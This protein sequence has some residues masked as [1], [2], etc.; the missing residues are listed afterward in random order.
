MANVVFALDAS[1]APVAHAAGG[2]AFVQALG[3]DE[4]PFNSSATSISWAFPTTA[5]V[6]AGDRVIV[7]VTWQGVAPATGTIVC[8]DGVGNTYTVDALRNGGSYPMSAICSAN[9]ATALPLG[10]AINVTVPAAYYATASAAEFSGIVGTGAWDRG[11]SQFGDTTTASTPGIISSGPTSI[12]TQ[13]DELVLG[14]FA[15]FQAS[16]TYSL[17]TNGTTNSCAL[18]GTPTSDITAAPDRTVST[19]IVLLTTYCVVSATGA[20]APRISIPGAVQHAMGFPPGPDTYR[21]FYSAS[22]AT[23][24][25]ATPAVTTSTALTALPS[26]GS[27]TFGQNVQFTAT[28]SPGPPAGDVT[29]MDGSV[30][31]GSAVPLSAG[32]ATLSTATLTVGSHPITAVYGGNATNAA[33][34]SSLLTQTVAMTPQTITFGGLVDKLPT[35]V[36]FALTASASSGLTVVF[37]STTSAVCSVSGAT[38]HLV[39]A[40]T[41]SIQASQPGTANYGSAPPVTQSFAVKAL[42]TI[43]FGSLPEA[44]YGA[45]PSPLTAT[46]SS[47]LAVSFVSTTPPVCTTSGT[48]GATLTILGAGL[49]SIDATQIGSDA[50]R[51]AAPVEQHFT[52]D[53]AASSTTLVISPS[54]SQAGD[55]V[56][57]QASVVPAVTGTA[58]PGGSLSFLD[59]GSLLATVNLD[60]SGLATLSTGG[61]G[62]GTHTFVAQYAGSV[63]FTGSLGMATLTVSARPSSGGGSSH[64]NPSPAAPQPQTSDSGGGGG[65]PLLSAPPAAPPAPVPPPPP[66]GGPPPIVVGSQPDG[67]TTAAPGDGVI[68]FIAADAPDHT[69]QA[70]LRLDPALPGALP[71]SMQLWVIADTAPKLPETANPA[72]LGGGVAEPLAAPLDIQLV[73][74]DRG[75]G[76]VVPLPDSIGSLVI[77]VRLPQPAVSPGPGEQ[78]VWLMEVDD[79][80]GNFL[81]YA[82][83]P[84]TLDPG[85][86]QVV[87]LIPVSQLRGTLFLPVLL[88]TAY[89]RNFD[90]D[91]HMW[92]SPFADGVDF[93]VAAPQWTRMQVLAPPISQRLPV[94]NA[95]TGEMGW[96]DVGG[97]GLVALDDG[98]PAVATEVAAP[99]PDAAAALGIAAPADVV[100]FEAP[101]LIESEPQP[102]LTMYAVQAGDTLKG[103]A[104]QSGASVLA[105]I[106]ANPRLDPDQLTIGQQLQLP[107][108]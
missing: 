10:T 107:L 56:V 66:P 99:V 72:N 42:Q 88:R 58:A 87:L 80:G 32:V 98:L 57:L 40:G 44:T 60:T 101:A 68:H 59:N 17:P 29:F 96:V 73:A 34:T 24:R 67:A 52:I 9:A 81:G 47:L 69:N 74:I 30:P 22:V 89:V 12:T 2:I 45:I 16:T 55:T 93:G 26:G 13:A 62:T 18:S 5:A 77:E 39:G 104:A 108:P 33:S 23:Y 48:N 49:C 4:A 63:N 86:Q 84:S 70:E 46:S 83:P 95:F 25:G 85:T 21:Y 100:P 65:V 28:V 105:L 54:S 14:A 103:I 41:C 71:S 102:T 92:S 1:F 75:S 94:L 90:P 76:Q 15:F 82:R 51:A 8:S 19:A 37:Q 6:A 53:P 61:T 64:S 20:Y 7:S 78:A 31:I 11:A 50:Y 38:V 43:T 97:V 36:N 91:A 27:S 3:T 35:D 106:A 79:A